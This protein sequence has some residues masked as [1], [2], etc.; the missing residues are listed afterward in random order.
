MPSSTACTGR[1]ELAGGPD[2]DHAQP[3]G[4]DVAE[5]VQMAQGQDLDPV[6]ARHLRTD[7]P[8]APAVRRS[9]V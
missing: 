4:A 5:A 7:W 1:Q 2:L 8:W 9:A 3:A 6:L